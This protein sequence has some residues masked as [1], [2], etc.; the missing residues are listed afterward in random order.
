MERAWRLRSFVAS[1]G[2]QDDKIVIIVAL[3][4]AVGVGIGVGA[5]VRGT[6]STVLFA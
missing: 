2:P 5:R 4:A 6:P 1:C 3:V